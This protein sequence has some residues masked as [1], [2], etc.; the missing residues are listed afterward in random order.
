MTQAALDLA[1]P[2]S[3]LT[4]DRAS[5][6]HVQTACGRYSVAKLFLN[7]IARY[8]AWLRVPAHKHRILGTHDTAEQA[9]EQCQA[10]ADGATHANR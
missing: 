2:A 9:Q 4:W 10:H 6:Y 5:K 1:P 7:G 8:E 3:T